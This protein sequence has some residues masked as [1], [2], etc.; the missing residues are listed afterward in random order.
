MWFEGRLL[1]GIFFCAGFFL[2]RTKFLKGG[3]RR[4]GI[5]FHYTVDQYLTYLYTHTHATFCPLV[6]DELLVVLPSFVIY[7][8]GPYCC[9]IVVRFIRFFLIFF[10]TPPGHTT[11]SYWFCMLRSSHPIIIF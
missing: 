10:E 1:F 4:Q 6:H 2:P 7:H 11:S 3:R 9:R 8:R 5:G